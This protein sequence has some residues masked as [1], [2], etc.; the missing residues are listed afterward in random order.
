L[1]KTRSPLGLHQFVRRRFN[2]I[3]KDRG[4]RHKAMQRR[5][6]Y[7]VFT[8]EIIP[9]SIFVLKVYPNTYRVKP[10]LGNQGY[11]AI[12]MDEKEQIVDFVEITCPQDGQRK[13]DD[14]NKTVSRGYGNIHV[15]SPCE[16]ID[17][18]SKFIYFTCQKKAQK[19]YSNCTLVLVIDF[20]PPFPEH[21]RLCS[22]KL[23]RLAEQIKSIRF[24]AKRVF[25]LI[26]PYNEVLK[27]PA[28]KSLSSS[29]ISLFNLKD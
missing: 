6:I 27:L 9:L 21:R 28:E 1:K 3:R 17:R 23:E 24:K 2:K 25:L 22:K 5:G 11:D 29:S 26:L 13:A 12:I 7:K 8:D 14:A 16:N 10:V 15:Y 19:D 20:D 4:E 18:L